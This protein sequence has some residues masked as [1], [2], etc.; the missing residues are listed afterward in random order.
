MQP[1]RNSE[2]Q[3]SKQATF[4]CFAFFHQ[5]ILLRYNNKTHI[6]KNPIPSDFINFI[7]LWK[8]LDASWTSDFF[9]LYIFRTVYLDC[10]RYCENTQWETV[11]ALKRACKE[12]QSL[13]EASRSYY[14]ENYYSLCCMQQYFVPVM[15][16]DGQDRCWERAIK[17]FGGNE[18]TTQGNAL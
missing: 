3:N 14:N 9:N 16:R 11:T 6:I 10:S 4:K 15:G 18:G 7:E 17:R 1:C 12:A 2:L 13:V 5:F 8:L